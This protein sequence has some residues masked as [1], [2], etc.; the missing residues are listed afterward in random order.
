MPELPEVETVKESLKRHLLN[1]KI[2]SVDVLY[3]RMIL[4]PLEDFKSS[5]VNA[6]ISDIRRKGK[7]LIFIFDNEKVLISHLRM[8]GKY[9]YFNEDDPITKHARVV[10]HLANNEKVVYDDSRCFGTM[11]LHLLN[12]LN[13]IP[14]ISKLG[15]EP[16]DMTKDELYAKLRNKTSYIKTALLDQTLVAGLGNIYVDETLFESKINPYKIAKDVTLD[17]CEAILINASK[18]L[19]NAIKEGGST[20]SSYHPENGV[21]GRFQILLKAYGKQNTPCV[22]CHTILRKDECNGRGTVYCPNCQNVA[23]RVGIYGKIASGK[24][25]I[26]K[27]VKS[28]KYPVFSSDEF[29]NELYTKS[30][31]FKK[32]LIN[33]FGENRLNDNGTISKSQIKQIIT[34]DVNKKKDLE[35]I[36]HPLVKR[37]IEKFIQTNRSNKILFLE[38]P[39]LFESNC[40]KYC[41]YVIGVNASEE[42]QIRNLKARGSKN[43]YLDLQL[44]S[45]SKVDKYLSKCDFIIDNNYS[46]EELYQSV[47][48]IINIINKL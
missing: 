19:L 38:I 8:E 11:E 36:I 41:D 46:L 13:H 1:K 26:N 23:K 18:I 25:T 7:Y 5:L 20:I 2:L 47:D 15:K 21:D 34:N 22:Y 12:D 42:I 35:N 6:T 3:E 24:S 44:N 27:Y 4:T 48:K 37:G 40:Q 31:S 17:E 14:S 45:T 33:L 9:M 39:L 32:Q 30:L 28:K 29:V 10:F 43:P 16:M